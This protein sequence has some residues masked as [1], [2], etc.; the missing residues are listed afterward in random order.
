MSGDA[1]ARVTAG[2]VGAGVDKVGGSTTKVLAAPYALPHTPADVKKIL[3]RPLVKPTEVSKPP[4]PAFNYA[5]FKQEKQITLHREGSVAGRVPGSG[6]DRPL[7]HVNP[8]PEIAPPPPAGPDDCSAGEGGA[9]VLG[10]NP[11]VVDGGS[12]VERVTDDAGVTSSHGSFG[13]GG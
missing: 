11:A 2:E 13:E 3:E 9:K 6:S 8:P 7:V 4:A 12:E 1:K 5:R 10:A